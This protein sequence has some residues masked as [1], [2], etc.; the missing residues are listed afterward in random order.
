MGKTFLNIVSMDENLHSMGNRETIQETILESLSYLPVNISANN[1]VIPTNKA[2]ICSL[3]LVNMPFKETQSFM[4]VTR[5]STTHIKKT[6]SCQESP[7]SGELPLKR[8]LCL[9]SKTFLNV[10]KSMLAHSN[11]FAMLTQEYIYLQIQSLSPKKAQDFRNHCT[12]SCVTGD[13]MW[14]QPQGKKLSDLLSYFSS[15]P[16]EGF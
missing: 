10:P 9:L 6:S 12:G 5:E 3:N 7:R 8:L 2:G 15:H 13:K 16:G 11:L 1:M 14:L 4:E